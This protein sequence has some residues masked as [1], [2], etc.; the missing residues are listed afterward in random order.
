MTDLSSAL[1]FSALA[2]HDPHSGSGIDACRFTSASAACDASA[3]AIIEVPTI[4]MTRRFHDGRSL[5]PSNA[6]V[7]LK[8]LDQKRR[9]LTGRTYFCAVR[10]KGLFGISAVARIAMARMISIPSDID[11]HNLSA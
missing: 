10:C 2:A 7:V 8:S 4:R 5:K 11:H 6:R 9:S 1:Q 3:T